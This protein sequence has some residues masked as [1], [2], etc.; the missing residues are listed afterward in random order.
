MSV[1]WKHN[2][3]LF[4][5]SHL[6]F[7]IHLWFPAGKKQYK[8]FSILVFLYKYHYEQFSLFALETIT[9]SFVCFF[10]LDLMAFLWLHLITGHL[11]YSHYNH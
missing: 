4:A 2:L 5:E 8:L 9:F 11:S 7:H 3:S 10:F 1:A 6:I